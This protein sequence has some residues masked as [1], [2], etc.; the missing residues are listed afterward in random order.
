MPCEGSGAIDFRKVEIAYK[1]NPIYKENI[2]ELIIENNFLE[3]SLCAI[4]I[5]LEKL[6]ILDEIIHKA[7]KNGT[8]NIMDFWIGHKT[9]DKMRLL[10]ELNKFSEHEKDILKEL[11]NN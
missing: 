3:A 9:K 1:N 11:L 8:I 5:E 10:N 4:F 2:K 7:S 6:Q